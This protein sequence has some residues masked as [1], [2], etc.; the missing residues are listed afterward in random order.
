MKIRSKTSNFCSILF[1]LTT[2]LLYSNELSNLRFQHLTI[3]DGLSHSKVNVV[4]QD[5]LG[6]MWFGT[7]DGVNKYDGYEITI[8]QNNPYDP[9]S[10]SHNLIRDIVEDRWGNLWIATDA[11]G[12]N[13]YNRENDNFDHFFHEPADSTS[14][15]SDF[16]WSIAEDQNG[17]LW[18]GTR[19]GLNVLDPQKHTFQ[20]I[21]DKPRNES[22]PEPNYIRSITFD[23]NGKL[24]IGTFGSGL[25]IFDPKNQNF[26]HFQHN[27]ENSNSLSGDFIHSIYQDR[28]NQIWIGTENGSLN[29]YNPDTK[30]FTR[31]LGPDGEILYAVRS[32]YDDDQNY[33]WIGSRNG[34]YL[35]NQKTE[36]M[37]L[38]LSEMNR[39]N[40]LSNQSIQCIFEDAKGDIWLGTRGGINYINNNHTSIVHYP[41]VLN[42]RRYL[43]HQVIFGF[44]EDRHGNLWIGSESGGINYL[45]KNSGLFTYYLHDPKNPNSLSANNI[46]TIVEDREGNFWIGTFAGGLNFYN[47]KNNRFTHFFHDPAD[48][49]TISNNDVYSVIKDQDG[50]IWSTTHFGVSVYLRSKNRFVRYTHNPDVPTSLSHN[51]CKVVYEDRQGTIWVGTFLGLNRYNPENHTFMRFLYDMDDANSFSSSFIRTL[52]EDSKRRFWVGTQ[53]GGLH[54]FNREIGTSITFME[55]DGLPNNSINGILEDDQNNL[56]LSTNKGISRFNPETRQFYNFDED[57]GFQ[58]NQFNYNAYCRGHD[59]MLYFGGINGING[60]YADSIRQNDYVPPVVITD[61]QIFNKSVKIGDENGILQKHISETHSITLPYSA[62]VITFKFAALN[63]AASDKNQYEYRL[64]GFE[65]EWNKVGTRRTATYTNLDPRRYVFHVKGSNNHGLWNEEGASIQLVISPP[66]WQMLWFRIFMIAGLL[67]VVLALYQIRTQNIRKKNRELEEINKKLHLQIEEREKAEKQIQTQLEEKQVLLKEIHHRVKNNLQVI[68]SLLRL[69]SQQITDHYSKKFFH[70]CE[71]RVRSM[72]LVHEKLYQSENLA[73]IDFGHYVRDLLDNIFRSYNAHDI[74]KVVQI[75]EENLYLG[76]DMAIPLGLVLNEL[77]SN[78]IQHAF[79]LSNNGHKKIKIILLKRKRDII[80]MVVQDNGCGFPKDI[81]FKKT[82]SLGLKLVSILV[83]DQLKGEL[84]LK[85]NPGTTF[86]LQFKIKES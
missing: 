46:K 50:N 56:W 23:S 49:T 65:T 20:C 14:I 78:A 24:W 2:N 34:L 16:L 32:I 55:K 79:P 12:L 13:R 26:T 11:G 44:I 31:Y 3:K 60:F 19:D 7:N 51:D 52:Y 43:N 83:F 18:I 58:S 68:C 41:A 47:R 38:I 10:L 70:S 86:S 84:N 59:G 45:D 76:I 74:D 36:T 82:K 30:T 54:L 5:R 77:V 80:K 17:V 48:S 71:D 81:D 25:Y 28:Q 57:D 37:K 35:F 62:S 67:L 22:H 27:P 4:F 72:A 40:S 9:A 69:E 64:E 1:L 39:I 6:Y 29:R 42:D 21:H 8:Y 66:F 85:R 61:F 73:Q 53:G 33:L 75:E 63:Y 15:S